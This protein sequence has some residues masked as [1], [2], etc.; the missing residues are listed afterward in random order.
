MPPSISVR[1]P[2]SASSGILSLTAFSCDASTTAPPPAVP[3]IISCA[4]A[5]EATPNA[6][7]VDV[8][9]SIL[10]APLVGLVAN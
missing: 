5:T 9:I 2:K 4:L 3:S 1:I 8:A 7:S 10:T 6:A